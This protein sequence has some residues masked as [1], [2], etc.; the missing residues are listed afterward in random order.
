MFTVHV[1]TCLQNNIYTKKLKLS[2]SDISDFTIFSRPSW[3]SSSLADQ[4]SYL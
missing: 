3:Y 4:Y 2:A 1:H